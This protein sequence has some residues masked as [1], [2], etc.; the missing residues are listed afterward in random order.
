MAEQF[1][2]RF[3]NKSYNEVQE[4]LD[5]FESHMNQNQNDEESWKVLDQNNS[6]NEEINIGTKSD[7]EKKS[8]SRKISKVKKPNFCK[9]C[10]KSF[11]SKQYLDIHLKT[12][13][14]KIK[15]SI[16][17]DLCEKTFGHQYFLKIHV[18]ESHENGY[19]CESCH[20]IFV[21][22]VNLKTHVKTVHEKL[23]QFEC[24]SCEKRFGKKGHLK[25]H[26]RT[27]SRRT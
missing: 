26:C 2:C 24:D 3:C 14:D 1:Q 6:K 23:K 15:D 19:T 7:S 21:K 4:F 18:K 8:T 9:N 11:S 10:E 22:K 25:S 5:H 12:V 16:K 20:K 17:C 27:N 13:H